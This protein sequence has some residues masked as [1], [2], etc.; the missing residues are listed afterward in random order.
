MAKPYRAA[1]QRIPFIKMHGL[2]NDFVLIDRREKVLEFDAA[3]VTRIADRHRGVGFDQ[4]VI[5]DASADADADARINFLNS[6]GSLAG[7]C[8]NGTRCAAR[9]LMDQSA[10]DEISLASGSGLLRAVRLADG[11]IKVGMT[12][13]RLAWRDIPLAQP[14][15]TLHVPLR[16]FGLGEPVAVNM[17]NPHAVFFVDDLDSL[18]IPAIGPTLERHPMFPERANIGFAQI[19]SHEALRLRVFERGAGLTLACGSGACAAVVAAVRREL[20]GP[21]CQVQLDGGELSI[22]WAGAG[23]VFMTGPTAYSFEGMLVGEGNH[24]DV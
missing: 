18:D 4:L 19:V 5:L 17:G 2:G 15:D 1:M 6:D 22:A 8:G 9:Y 21:A 16:L 3:F 14:C 20:V 11:Q 7:A 13:P 24:V 10:I 12:E 23:P